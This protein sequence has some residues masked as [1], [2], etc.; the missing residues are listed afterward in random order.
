MKQRNKHIV[1]DI[2]WDKLSNL[3]ESGTQQIPNI[4]GSYRNL[5]T[6]LVVVGSNF[7]V[8]RNVKSLRVGNLYHGINTGY[9]D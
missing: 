8:D 9:Q 5:Q 7:S 3:L 2:V 1:V 4:V 6:C